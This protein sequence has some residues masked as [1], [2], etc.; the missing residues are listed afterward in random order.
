MVS[1][2]SEI[3]YHRNNPD[4]V[5]TTFRHY[6]NDFGNKYLPLLIMIMS[7]ICHPVIDVSFT[8]VAHS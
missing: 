1:V 3:P 8:K 2:I 7:N 6:P 4:E 5:I